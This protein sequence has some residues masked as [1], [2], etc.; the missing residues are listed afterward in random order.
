MLS[1]GCQLIASM[2]GGRVKRGYGEYGR[3]RMRIAE[4]DPIFDG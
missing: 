2:I 1:Y 4:K 3:T